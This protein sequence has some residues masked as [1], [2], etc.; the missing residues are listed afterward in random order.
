MKGLPIKATRHAAFPR[1]Y[2]E[3]TCCPRL[4]RDRIPFQA[5]SKNSIL[6]DKFN[7]HSTKYPWKSING[8]NFQ[9]SLSWFVARTKERTDVNSETQAKHEGK[10]RS[11]PLGSLAR[12]C[13]HP[14]G[15]SADLCCQNRSGHPGG[16]H[17]H[18]STW[19]IERH[20]SSACL[21]SSKVELKTVGVRE[22][23]LP[24]I[25]TQVSLG[26]CPPWGR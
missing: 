2:L 16:C 19:R 10:C 14:Q 21:S 25:L 8:G 11:C 1:T 26:A 22:R 24:S 12:S 23:P 4:F 9:A 13:D 15:G 7:G 18:V 20:H 6:D 5:V 17:L 3:H